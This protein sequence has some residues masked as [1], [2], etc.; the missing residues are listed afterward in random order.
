MLVQINL[1]FERAMGFKQEKVTMHAGM[2]IAQ[3]L[4]LV[5]QRL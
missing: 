1:K 5:E 4:K 2:E 3:W